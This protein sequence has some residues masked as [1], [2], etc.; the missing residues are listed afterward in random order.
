MCN[1]GIQ[2]RIVKEE[3]LNYIKTGDW[4]SI[5]TYIFNFLKPN[6]AYNDNQTVYKSCVWFSYTDED[7]D[8]RV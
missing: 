1:F 8:G 3:E 2:M 5:L 6:I 7:I 4:I